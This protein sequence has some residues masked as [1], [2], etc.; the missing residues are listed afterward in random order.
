MGIME[1]KIEATISYRDFI[2]VR[3]G[4]QWDNNGE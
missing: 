3:I 1:N 2:G 4:K